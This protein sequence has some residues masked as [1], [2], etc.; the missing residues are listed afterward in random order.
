MI[1]KCTVQYDGSLYSGWQKQPGL[2]TIQEILESALSTI[3]KS[4]VVVHGSGRTDKGVHAYG[5]VFHFESEL[6]MDAMQYQKAL[7]ALIPD[8]IRITE[9]LE[10]DNFHARF[11]ATEKT[12]RYLINMGDVDVF[13]LNYEYQIAKELDVAKM[14]EATQVFLGTHD[15]TSYNATELLIVKNQIRTIHTFEVLQKD[16]HLEITIS[17]DGFLRYMVRMLVAALIEVGIGRLSVSDLETILRAQ[18]KDVFNKNVPACGLYLM[19]V[20]YTINE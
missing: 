7:N 16:K 13:K 2:S 18:D 17:G 9:V 6:N 4:E 3:H 1:Y 19:H 8:S 15:F 20:N 5:Q 11:D 10:K 12:Y 14:N